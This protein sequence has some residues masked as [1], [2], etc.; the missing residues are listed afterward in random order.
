MMIRGKKKPIIKQGLE[1]L[2]K[3][4]NIAYFNTELLIQTLSQNKLKICCHP[5]NLGTILISLSGLIK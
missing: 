5:L 4:F 1:E 2:K 3:K